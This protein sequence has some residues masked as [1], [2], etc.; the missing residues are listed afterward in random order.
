MKLNYDNYFTKDGEININTQGWLDLRSFSESIIYN[1]VGKKNYNEDLISEA[2]IVCA[3]KLSSYDSTKNDQLG[4]WLYWR[5]R[6]VISKQ[7][8][9]NKKEIPHDFNK[10][11]LL[12][13]SYKNQN[14]I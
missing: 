7:A 11:D 4:G 14:Q 6:G 3:E 1:V 8:C 9:K 13:D 5:V 12:Y 2:M 10:G